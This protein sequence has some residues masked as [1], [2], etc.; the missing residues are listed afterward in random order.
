V[1]EAHRNGRASK[2]RGS[3]RRGG[4]VGSMDLPAPAGAPEITWAVQASAPPPDTPLDDPA[5]YFNR[6]LSWLDFNWRVV[7]Q[8]MDARVPLL[9]RVRFLAIAESNLDEFFAK[10]VGGLRRQWEEGVRQP[11]PDGRTPGEQLAL[12]RVAAEN[13]HR[14]MTALWQDTL[15]PALEREAG[16]VIATYAALSAAQQREMDAYFRTNIYPI[17]TPLAVDPGHPFP[18]ISSQSLSLAVLLE[19]P[20]RGTRHFARVKIPT[21]RQRWIPLGPRLFFPVEEL[22]RRHA[23]DLFP[24]MRIEGAHLFR[25]IRSVDLERDDEEVEDLL[26]MISEELRARR[27]AP[28]VRLEAEASMPPIVRELLRNELALGADDIADV[29]GLLDLDGLYAIAD[30]PIPELRYEPWE[31]VTPRLLGE[32]GRADAP[33]GIFDV[34]R[35]GDVLVHHPYESFTST[36]QAFIEAAAAD[37]RVLAIKQTLY[38]TSE[39]SP[40]VQA[41]VHAAEAGKQVAA[42]VE[43]TARFDEEKNI[44]WA[45][46]LERAGVH[47]TY[48]LVGLKTHAKVVLVV[49]EE[50]DGMRTYCHI[51]TGNYHART[52]RLYTDIGL[53]TADPG[54]GRDV[55]NLFHYL[56]GYALEPEYDTLVVAPRDM[57]QT[58]LDRIDREITHQRA[59]GSGRI[60]AKM[61]A[62]DDVATVRKLYEAS[63]AGVRID[64]VVR[65][66]SRLRPGLPGIS[67]NIRVIS[68]LG[69]FLEHDRIFYFGNGGDPE[70]LI[71]SADWRRR[72]LEERVEAAIP[73]ENADL[74]ARLLS[75]LLRA[76]ADNHSAWD[77]RPDGSYALRHPGAGAIADFQRGLMADAANRREGDQPWLA[78]TVAAD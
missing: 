64:L 15:K 31:P 74:K 20:V 18:F 40:V 41:L 47:V 34:I 4:R 49:R 39:N 77:L 52:A 24:G 54:I 38:R 8:A 56:T 6:E 33:A 23:G 36:V 68:I 32:S 2:R 69:R 73:V 45:Q 58:F 66:H 25:V 42:L 35:A 1:T 3:G 60:I 9:E 29:E 76:L 43:V 70:V 50:P 72:N 67:E 46:A 26:L 57:R 11:S 19:H 37:R 28:V 10:R 61:N 65:G 14:T 30:L 75:V 44:A 17:L 5:L 63:Q 12:I 62:L 71:G 7:H 55:V 78:T 22:V 59:G 51:G 16:L 21:D 27:F 48:G 53:L 13:M